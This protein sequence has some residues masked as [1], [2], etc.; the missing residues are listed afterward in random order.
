MALS[1][2]FDS[3]R[4]PHNA[5]EHFKD[6]LTKNRINQQLSVEDSVSYHVGRL[7]LELDEIKED[8][9]YNGMDIKDD[10]NIGAAYEMALDQVLR[11]ATELANFS[12]VNKDKGYTD[13][14]LSWEDKTSTFQ[15]AEIEQQLVSAIN[16][17]IDHIKSDP[18]V[19][20]QDVSLPL[21]INHEARYANDGVGI[22]RITDVLS[23]TN[24]GY[25]PKQKL[26]ND[27]AATA[28]EMHSNQERSNSFDPT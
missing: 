9:T 6:T 27:D 24:E 18:Q 15:P 10:A 26:N 2:A 25:T 8:R 14:H 4:A 20:F 1:A 23:L 5:T 12:L 3:S 22:T 17:Y 11:T 16:D 19:N 21:A 28:W 7:Q 13:T